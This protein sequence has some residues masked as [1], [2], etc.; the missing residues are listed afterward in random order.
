MS[1]GFVFADP[2]AYLPLSLDERQAKVFEM[3]PR[4]EELRAKLLKIGG[5]RVIWH[6]REDHVGALVDTGRAFKATVK[7]ATGQ[8]RE[9]H[10]NAAWLFLHGKGEAFTG[11]ALSKD[12]GYWRQHS[13]GWDGTHVLETTTARIAYYGFMPKQFRFA[14]S[15][16]P[17]REIEA[18]LVKTTQEN[19]NRL[20]KLAE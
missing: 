2:G 13:W 15:Q 10:K 14:M 8:G 7:Q 12:D 11:Y 20:R 4:A 9:C 3:C 6:L 5:E 1:D 18:F 19:R 16:L 17:I